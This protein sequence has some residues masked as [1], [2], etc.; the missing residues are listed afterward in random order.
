MKFGTI[1][2]LRGNARTMRRDHKK[3]GRKFKMIFKNKPDEYLVHDLFELHKIY[4]EGVPS[5]VDLGDINTLF[6]ED[7]R[8]YGYYVSA[9]EFVLVKV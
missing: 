4:K 6:L 7:K 1:S 9:D 3:T 5:G 8:G 2:T